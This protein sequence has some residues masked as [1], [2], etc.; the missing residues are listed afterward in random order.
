MVDS[1]AQASFNATPLWF[2]NADP[3]ELLRHAPPFGY[4]FARVTPEVLLGFQR[5]ATVPPVQRFG[6]CAV[7]GNSG[8]LRLQELG[9]EID[10]HDA[11]FRV[12]HAPLPQRLEGAYYIR[13]T[14][15][16]TTWRVVTSN[17]RAVQLKDLKQ[18]LVVICDQPG[19]YGCQR[20]LFQRV[21]PRTHSL[22]PR[23]LAAVRQFAGRAARRLEPSISDALTESL[24]DR[25]LAL[26]QYGACVRAALPAHACT[27]TGSRIPLAGFVAVALA[28]RVC[29]GRID[30]YGL[31]AMQ[32][33]DAEPLSNASAW[34]REERLA[35]TYRTQ[36]ALPRRGLPLYPRSGRPR[37]CAYYWVGGCGLALSGPRGHAKLLLG[38]PG[39][40]SDAAYHSRARD[41]AYHDFAAHARTL[42]AWNC[43]GAIRMR[44]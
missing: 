23:F 11:V 19:I 42:L 10:A 28:L 29:H 4:R 27:H 35:A 24:G 1:D 25:L 44:V 8:A 16:R 26:D 43:S 41:A 5:N 38:D 17:W 7:V 3:T 13:Y 37:V 39:L 33:A 9:R 31:S 21:R 22:S 6:T 2:A 36:L 15:R 40:T 18:R 14:G 32:H 30:T 34:A 20:K 12:N